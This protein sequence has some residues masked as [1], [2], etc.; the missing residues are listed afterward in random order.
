LISLSDSELQIV[1]EALHRRDRDPFLRDVAAEL[2]KYPEIGIGIIGRVC[3]KIQRQ[4]LAP[5]TGHNAG[6]KYSLVSRLHP[7]QADYGDVIGVSL[8]T[9]TDL[10]A[11]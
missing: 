11:C 4:H 9:Q 7:W 8:P 6:S 5:G 3:A 1:M 2:G 10:L